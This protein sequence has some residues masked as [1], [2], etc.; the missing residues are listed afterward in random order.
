MSRDSSL[1]DVQFFEQHGGIWTR[2]GGIVHRNDAYD[3]LGFDILMHM[4]REHFWYLGRHRCL[5]SALKETLV[6]VTAA[7]R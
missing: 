7:G 1:Q 4:Q 6:S 2:R 3:I 5:L